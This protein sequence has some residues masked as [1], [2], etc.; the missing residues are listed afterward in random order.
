LRLFVG[1]CEAVE[2]AYRRMVGR[3]ADRGREGDGGAVGAVGVAQGEGG[4]RGEL[5]KG[6]TEADICQHG[7]GRRRW[8]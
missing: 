5:L 6:D 3:E 8:R 4:R 1:V 2:Y 7:S